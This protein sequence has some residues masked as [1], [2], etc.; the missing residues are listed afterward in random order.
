VT[1]EVQSLDGTL[2][3]SVE[4]LVNGEVFRWQLTRQVRGAAAPTASWKGEATVN[5]DELYGRADGLS[6]PCTFVLR[7][8]NTEA[9]REKQTR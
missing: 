9:I 4:G 5:S 8:V 6:C 7:R 2:V 1:G 3:G